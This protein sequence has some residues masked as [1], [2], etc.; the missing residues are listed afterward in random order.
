MIFYLYLVLAQLAVG[1]NIVGSKYLLQDVSVTFL[2]MTRF[3]VAAFW[4]FL[5]Y[6]LQPK[7]QRQKQAPVEKFNK[8]DFTYLILQ[9]LCAGALFNLLLL[10][11]LRYTSASVAG[12][13]TSAIPAMITLFSVILLRERL[14]RTGVLS[15]IL[16]V[17]G[18]VIINLHGFHAGGSS[19][20]KGALIIILSLLP[21]SLYYVLCKIHRVRMP[22]IL[23][24]AWI[25]LINGIVI[26]PLLIVH[27][28]AMHVH[29]SAASW[30]V[31]LAVTVSTAMFY[32]FW[33]MGCRGVQASLAGMF[34]AIMPI[35][36]LLLSWA[37]LSETIT[38]L[39]AAG[40][41]LVIGSIFLYARGKG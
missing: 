26:L 17:L 30:C 3:W 6:Y 11:G 25:N 41:L 1:V 13:I 27:P 24:A 15:V 39:Q 8:Q 34:T 28:E 2:L 9:A 16:A 38:L 29:L 31:L 20:L 32:M 10:T 23:L 36:T 4:L 14:T 40:M 35:A 22:L 7:R 18:L 19:N 21:E 5:I 33:Y 12:I 37:F